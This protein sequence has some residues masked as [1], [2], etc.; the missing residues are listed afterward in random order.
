MEVIIIIREKVWGLGANYYVLWPSV[1]S[2]KWN[3]K[4]YLISN[5]EQ[6]MKE[7]SH[8]TIM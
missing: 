7:S 1:F 6:K 8:I 5:T 2:Y 3:L 4:M